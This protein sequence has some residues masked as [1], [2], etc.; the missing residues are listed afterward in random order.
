MTEE[1][2]TPL[3]LINWTK[4]FFEKKGIESPRL[5]A[6]LLLAEALSLPRIEL[7]AR[8]GDE[9]P[10]AKLAAFREMVRRRAAREPAQ[11]ILGCTEFCGYR[12]KTDRRALIPRPETEIIIDETVEM[13]KSAPEV[14]LA[15]IGTGSGCLAV[16]AA[17]KL[18][19]AQIV[20]CDISADAVSLAHENAE[21]HQVLPRI[22]FKCGDFEAVLAEFA[23]RFDALMA[24][25][26][27]VREDEL[28]ALAPELR[29]H[30]PRAALVAGPE[31]TEVAARI[32]AAAAGLLKPEGALVM[33][34]GAA[35]AARVR[36]M[37]D[38]EAALKF[39][40]FEKDFAGIERVAV[41]RKT[42]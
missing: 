22:T 42:T 4:A 25:P 23:G 3:K 27:Y 34:I 40:R 16:V 12:F 41:A 21:H 13:T 28:P 18:P 8:F 5:E 26:P 1:A 17:L 30:E 39:V 14:L 29:E 7:Y 9:V 35:Q 32:I 19:Q 11:Y 36:K 24:N 20:A 6:E 15:D 2:W 37:I 10:Q 38:A 31:G 33:E